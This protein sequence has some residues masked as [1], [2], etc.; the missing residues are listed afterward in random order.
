MVRHNYKVKMSNLNATRSF[1]AVLSHEEEKGDEE[2][3]EEINKA[4][5]KIFRKVGVKVKISYGEKEE[6]T[7]V[8]SAMFDLINKKDYYFIAR[9]RSYRFNGEITNYMTLAKAQ[10]LEN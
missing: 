6:F 1:E 8:A 3:R 10:K 2:L 9:I 7:D 4:F 5:L